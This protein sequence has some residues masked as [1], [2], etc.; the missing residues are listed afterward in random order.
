MELLESTD[1]KTDLL[2]KAA[3]QKQALHDEVNFLSEK[4]EKIVKTAL[5]VSGTLAAAY[6]TYQLFS[7]GDVRKKRKKTKVMLAAPSEEAEEIEEASSLTSGVVAKIGTVL[8]SQAS[9][10]LLALA[11][12][13]LSEYLENR[14]AAK[15]EKTS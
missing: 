4:T 6:L 8:A 11:K 15:H 7:D 2:R 9:V 14:A 13:K 3:N 10:F 12:E 5:I 1:P